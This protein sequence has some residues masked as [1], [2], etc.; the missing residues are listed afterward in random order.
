MDNT[1]QV[2]MEVITT[3]LCEECAAEALKEWALSKGMPRLINS[4][5]K[6]LVMFRDYPNTA[7]R[8]VRCG[9]PVK[10]CNFCFSHEALGQIKHLHGRHEDMF[11]VMKELET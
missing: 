4:I 8:C 11:S 10:V 7:T 5:D 2:C 9:R 6:T 1:C 3:P